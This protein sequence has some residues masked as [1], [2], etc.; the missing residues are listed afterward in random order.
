MRPA[1]N[2]VTVDL[3]LTDVQAPGLTADRLVGSLRLGEAGLPSL[4]I[5]AERPDGALLVTGSVP[6]EDVPGDDLEFD[7]AVDAAGWPLHQAG[8]WLPFALPVDGALTGTVTLGGRLESPTGRLEGVLEPVR[9]GAWSGGRLQAVLAFEPELIQVEQA[10]WSGPAGALEAR[11][12]IRGPESRLDLELGSEAL[13]LGEAPLGELLGG[14]L[15]GVVS[16]QGRLGGTLEEP[17]VRLAA[18]SDELRASSFPDL[19]WPFDLRADWEA[20]ALQLEARLGDLVQVDGGGSLTDEA[21]ELEFD[22]ASTALGEL[23]R[24]VASQT[25][26]GLSGAWAGTVTVEKAPQAAWTVRTRLPKLDLHYQGYSLAAVEPVVV[27]WAGEDLEVESL[28]L[29]D[30][31][32]TS[33]IFAAGRVGLSEPVSLA[34]NLQAGLEASWLELLL[35]DFQIDGRLEALARLEGNLS[36]PRLNGQAAIRRGSALSRDLPDSIEEIE[37]LVLFYP[38]QI[39]VDHLTAE[40]GGGDLRLTG[41]VQPGDLS[42][43]LELVA[44]DVTLNQPP[45]WTLR[46]G[47][48]LVLASTASG[49]E[50]RGVTHLERAFYLR[51]VEV[52]PVQL[53]QDFMRRRPTRFAETD[54]LLATTQLQVQVEG[55]QALQVRNNL[56]D[57]DGSIDLTIRGTMAQPVLFGTVEVDPDSTFTYGGNEYRVVRGQLSFANPYRIEPF[58]DLVAETEIRN[59]DVTLD[60]SGSIDRPVASFSSNPPL[61]DLDVLTLLA[62][63]EATGS[64]LLSGADRG[65]E[66]AA[67]TFLYGQAATAVSQRVN[68]LFGLDKLQI[69][70]LTGASGDIS[71]ARVTVGEQLSKD[72]YATWS[73]DPTSTAV[74][75]LEVEWQATPRLSVLLTQHGDS[76][77]AV[78]LQWETR[79]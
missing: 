54:D 51:D 19:S 50:V 32:G 58:I 78:D 71:A 37:G 18:H 22:V 62:T 47:A 16:V 8:A 28:Y 23:A 61:A 7:L 20:P 72:V 5:E 66:G 13:R 64:T 38:R 65:R 10:V 3:A 69:S 27:S 30:S 11:G 12:S 49:R 68:T 53:L 75:I 26:E 33:E 2:Q 59:Y 24:L 31:D 35:N 60:L 76:S 73:Y 15:D 17:N 70:P 21:A 39:V 6:Y 77:Y 52:G 63:G 56:A 74:Q 34:L 36:E 41:T 9:I 40:F 1:G 4:R 46:G 25:P 79:F 14:R 29:A 42:Y 43:R 55:P 57:L 44:D 48:E 67:E 45:G